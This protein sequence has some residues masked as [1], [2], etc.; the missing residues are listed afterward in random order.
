MPGSPAVFAGSTGT[1][2]GPRGP[3]PDRAATRPCIDFAV[4][5]PHIGAAASAAVMA[6]LRGLR[7]GSG[8][9]PA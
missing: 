5:Q 8:A 3:R 9:F 7:D 4:A 2:T 6:R 1:G